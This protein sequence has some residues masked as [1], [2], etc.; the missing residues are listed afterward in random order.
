[1]TGLKVFYPQNYFII[2]SKLNTHVFNSICVFY[3]PWRRSR[4][5][6][7][8]KLLTKVCFL[9]WE[10]LSTGLKIVENWNWGVE[11]REPR[12]GKQLL[13]CWGGWNWVRIRVRVYNL[14][15]WK[16]FDLGLLIIHNFRRKNEF[17]KSVKCA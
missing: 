4:G 2:S 15:W 3:F 9:F 17:V 6:Y 7:M 1:M 8:G 5:L 11:T 16:W 12:D 10:L 13:L 14:W